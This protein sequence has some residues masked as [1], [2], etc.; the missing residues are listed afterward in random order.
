MDASWHTRSDPHTVYQNVLNISALRGFAGAEQKHESITHL[1]WSGRNGVLPAETIFSHRAKM[2]SVSL[3]PTDDRPTVFVI[4]LQR[5]FS[6]FFFFLNQV[7]FLLS[8]ALGCVFFFLLVSVCFCASQKMML[9]CQYFW[10]L[11]ASWPA[12][13]PLP[14]FTESPHGYWNERSKVDEY[15]FCSNPVESRRTKVICTAE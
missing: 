5:C 9:C 7:V 14:P 3:P 2:A 12:A 6:T 10:G 13:P 15:T 11:P 4:H 8:S 1:S